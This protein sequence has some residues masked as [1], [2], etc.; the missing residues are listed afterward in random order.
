[1]Q[2]I[3]GERFETA[4]ATP[5]AVRASPNRQE[6]PSDVSG[7]CNRKPC[8]LVGASLRSLV[9]SAFCSSCFLFYLLRGASHPFRPMEHVS[10]RAIIPISRSQI[11]H[12][13]PVRLRSV[14][15]FLSIPRRP[16]TATNRRPDIAQIKPVCRLTGVTA[17]R[18]ILKFIQIVHISSRLNIF[19]LVL[20]LIL[21]RR[22]SI[23]FCTLKKGSIVVL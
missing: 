23:D 8:V 5:G 7:R 9:C 16:S 15:Y 2:R 1:M 3:N 10:T 12:T 4:V 18:D 14:K 21:L 11:A 19:S 22:S 13:R 20:L 17:P 6:V